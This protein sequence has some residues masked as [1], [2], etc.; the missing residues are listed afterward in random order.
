MMGYRCTDGMCQ[1]PHRAYSGVGCAAFYGLQLF[2]C[3][4]HVS[5]HVFFAELTLVHD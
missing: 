1:T 5:C 4:S 3:D 2:E